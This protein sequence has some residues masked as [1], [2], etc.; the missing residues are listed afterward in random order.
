MNN[1]DDKEDDSK[2]I[3]FVETVKQYCIPADFHRK[4]ILPEPEAESLPYD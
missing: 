3:K 1:K 4:Y 2:Q